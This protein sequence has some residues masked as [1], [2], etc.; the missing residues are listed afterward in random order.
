MGR[1]PF[2]W[3][4]CCC[5][6]RWPPGG[7]R[8][9]GRLLLE[10]VA[11]IPVSGG[12]GDAP[13]CGSRAGAGC[14]CGG[15]YLGFNWRALLLAS[16]GQQSRDDDGDSDDW[17]QRVSADGW[18]PL[19]DQGTGVVR[20]ARQDALSVV[21][22]GGR[23]SVAPGYVG[24]LQQ[25]LKHG[26][27]SRVQDRQSAT[28]ANPRADANVVRR[29]DVPTQKRPRPVSRSWRREGPSS[30]H[31]ARLTAGYWAVN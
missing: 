12:G 2:G 21:V 10:P 3:S 31:G 20:P 14:P 27:S 22:L 9:R 25:M 24:R 6:R 19:R 26:T 23:R 7:C 8:I 28:T 4:R 13:R 18:S 29:L 16:T 5:R 30:C 1:W 11:G 17:R 15:S